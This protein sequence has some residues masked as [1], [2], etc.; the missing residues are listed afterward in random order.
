MAAVRP[1]RADMPYRVLLRLVEAK[2]AG[3][4]A[5]AGHGYAG[6]DEFIAD[7]EA[8]DTS[9]AHHRGDHAGRFAL[10]R[11]LRRVRGFGFHLAALDL[12]QDSA[13]HEEALAAL[14]DDADWASRAADAQVDRLHGVLDGTAPAA[15]PAGE[16]D[17]AASTL[18][19]FR[20]ARDLRRTHGAEIGRASC[21][22][23]VGQ[24]V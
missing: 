3:T 20:E 4:Q 18:A 13:V 7:L 19:V 22:D 6:V 15:Q 5:Q 8:I 2:L 14:L 10:Q 11:V 17:V 21:R 12:R 9:L 16:N 1:R 24:S 23:R